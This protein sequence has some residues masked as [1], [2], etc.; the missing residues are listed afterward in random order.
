MS[1][2]RD[3]RARLRALVNGYEA[4]QAIYVAA[5]LGLADRLAAGPETTPALASACGADP[6]ALR[7]VLRA[8]AT[9]GVV[10]E[11]GDDRFGLGAAGAWLRSDVPGS[12]RPHALLSGARS[13]AA[14]GGLLGSVETGEAAFPK[15][16]G[17]T[18]FEYMAAHPELRALYDAAMAAAAEDRA[19]A[20]LGAVTF[21]E[22]GTVVD[23]G[24]GAGALLAAVLA[25][26]PTLRGV[27][28]ERPAAAAA[29]ARRFS[30][31]ALADR[32]RVE[33]GDFFARVPAGGDLY[34][35]SHILHNWD[36]SR[37]TA[38]LGTCRAAMRPAARL[39]VVEKV[40]P[41][42]AEPSPEMQELFMADLHM[43]AITGGLE[44]TREQ[45]AAL[46]AGAGL[47]LTQV[48]PMRSAD[49]VLDAVPV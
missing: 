17:A 45:Y 12:L 4:A 23:V 5:R 1:P 33:T 25:R 47:R 7:R 8:L 15:V 22:R 40:M 43:L 41:V 49:S 39:V 32:V 36:D 46:F 6:A 16:F 44:R 20:V 48:I 30:D 2:D 26:H 42:R 14:W 35:L 34:V 28:L 21:P 3:A 11:R 9:L 24:G 31:D 29:A 19:V 13:Y 27:L 38:I 18:T 10:V 37:A